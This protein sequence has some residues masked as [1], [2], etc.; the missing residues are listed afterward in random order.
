[1]F[2]FGISKEALQKVL[3]ITSPAIGA[4]DPAV[5]TQKQFDVALNSLIQT[6]PSLGAILV[7]NG[8]K[9]VARARPAANLPLHGNSGGTDIEY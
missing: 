9:F 2:D 6:T 1:M 4:S 7:D 5:L 8:T 3:G